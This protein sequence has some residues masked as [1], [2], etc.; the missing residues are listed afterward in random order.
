MCRF[1][2]FAD[3]LLLSDL[4]GEPRG[5]CWNQEGDWEL[6]GGCF[7]IGQPPIWHLPR[8]SMSSV[9]AG[10]GSFGQTEINWDKYGILSLSLPLLLV[11]YSFAFIL[12]HFVSDNVSFNVP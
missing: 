11:A 2:G 7:W 1:S 6:W 12:C 4:R 8:K 3:D 9:Q 5:G 10:V